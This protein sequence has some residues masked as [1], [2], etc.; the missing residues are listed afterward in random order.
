EEFDNFGQHY[1]F[2]YIPENEFWIDQGVKEDERRFFIDHLIVEHRLMAKGMAYDDALGEAD[3]AE[4]KER[5]RAGDLRKVRQKDQ[6][7]PEAENVHKTLWRKLENGV[8]VWIVSGRLVRSAFDI[9]FT[10]GGH[11]KVYEFVPMNEVW[12]DDAL[13]EGERGFLLLH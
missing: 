10:A 4:R 3:Q 11:D 2:S 13:D 12:I 8:E 7:L 5:R 9:D 6:A 1:A